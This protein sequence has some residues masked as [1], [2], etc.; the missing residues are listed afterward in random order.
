MNLFSRQP[1]IIDAA[2]DPL[3]VG[4]AI[5]ILRWQAQASKRMNRLAGNYSLRRQAWIL[6]LIL[7][8][9]AGAMVTSLILQ[10]SKSAPGTSVSYISHHIGEASNGKPPGEDTVVK[11]DSL[12]HRK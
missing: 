4:I 5:K 2:N 3:A 8:V 12:T 11:T 1:K 10:P 9:L 7:V 6:A